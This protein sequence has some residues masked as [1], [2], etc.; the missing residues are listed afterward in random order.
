[1][2][3]EYRLLRIAIARSIISQP[4][5]LLLDEATSAL[6][7][8]PEEIVQTAL[9]N[10]SKGRATIAIAHKLATIRKADNIVVMEKGE[11]IKQ[12]THNSLIAAIGSYAR[13]VKAQDLSVT[14]QHK[15]D[16]GSPAADPE[17]DGVE[18]KSMGL[19]GT[20]S[21][22]STGKDQET[23]SQLDYDDF[24]GWKRLGLLKSI[25]TIIKR[26]PE[27]RSTYSLLLIA[28]FGAGKSNA[29]TLI[30]GRF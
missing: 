14:S 26:S 25:Y 2:K 17:G 12:G 28:C 10:V 4:K 6:D 18:E 30:S 11:I 24:D 13:L 7:P 16:T 3:S 9:D 27:L 22:H 29:E 15:V 21:R 5:I 1:M 8:H 23:G 19:M 20:T